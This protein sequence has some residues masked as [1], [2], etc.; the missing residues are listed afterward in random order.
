MTPGPAINSSPSEPGGRSRPC[1]STTRARSGGQTEPI[2]NGSARSAGIVAGIG[3]AVQTLVSVGPYRFHIAA[4]GTEPRKPPERRDRKDLAREK[5]QPRR[6]IIRPVEPPVLGQER[7]DRRRRVPDA[8][9]LLGDEIAERGRIFPQGLTHEHER[10]RRAARR[11]QIEYRE[12]EVERGV[13]REPIVV[14]P[15]PERLRAPVEKRERIGMGKHHAF[16]LAG[17]ARGEEDVGQVVAVAAGK[18]GDG[19]SSAEDFRPAGIARDATSVAD[20]PP[21]EAGCRPVVAVVGFDHN[22]PG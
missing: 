22:Q 3:Y 7:Q 5:H 10:R 20:G 16:G 6:P 12:I 4:P 8:D 14:M 2:G 15:R 18:S 17:R 21:V 9:S 1:S 11:E 13:R 19:A